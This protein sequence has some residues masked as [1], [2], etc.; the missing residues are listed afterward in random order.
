MPL[1]EFA[2]IERYFRSC[3]APRADVLLGVGDDAA[4]LASP[5]GRELVAATDTL[6]AGVH[7]PDG[8]P[9]DSI[10]HRALAVNL[11][12]LAA[13]G[14]QPAWALLALTLPKADEDWIDG[15]AGG[16]GALA[17]EHAV[18]LV[19]GDTTGGKLCITVQTLGFVPRGA[20]LTRGGG[21]P[22]DAVFVT[23]TP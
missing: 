14:A 18:A 20:A 13:M 4:L 7:F 17:R 15:F 22:D 9:P 21:R 12:D 23:G 3:G 19:G 11:S 16:R 8:S 6:V 1:S 2:L 10:G 5:A